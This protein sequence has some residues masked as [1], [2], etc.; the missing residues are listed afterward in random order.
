MREKDHDNTFYNHKPAN[1]TEELEHATGTYTNA[2]KDGWTEL[3]NKDFVQM[4]MAF[5]AELIEL[6]LTAP[7]ANAIL[8]LLSNYMDLNN[9]FIIGQKDIAAALNKSVEMV[10][11]S[12]RT[13]KER[14][15]LT[16][17]KVNKQNVYFINPRIFCKV[18]GSYKQKLIAEY[19]KIN[20][21]K[22]EYKAENVDL[23]VIKKP[24]IHVKH[25][26]ETEHKELARPSNKEIYEM[27]KMK[28]VL[29]SLDVADKV[30][31]QQ[32][33][34]NREI[35]T[36]KDIKAL[37]QS[38]RLVRERENFVRQESRKFY[39]DRQAEAMEKLENQESFV[40]EKFAQ[41]DM[42]ELQDLQEIYNLQE[43]AKLEER[44]PE[45]FKRMEEEMQIQSSIL[46]DEEPELYDQLEDYL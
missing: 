1:F 22:E 4:A 17:Y 36:D 35:P 26:F 24:N 29:N 19:I 43:L 6:A 18:S 8:I 9:T 5:K 27:N 37:R 33:Y 28:E 16:T 40:K 46:Q 23:T 2:D 7:T 3:K 20:P 12:I 39:D 44:Y 15:F 25:E 14:D 31:L 21:D 30:Y 42:E 11:K 32:K 45:E 10:K 41:A 34:I 38:N 13:L